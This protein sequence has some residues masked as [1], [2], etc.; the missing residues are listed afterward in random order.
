MSIVNNARADYYNK[1]LHQVYSPPDFFPGR[2]GRMQ[3]KKE[4]PSRLVCSF[5][6]FCLH[7]LYFGG[8]GYNCNVPMTFSVLF[9]CKFEAKSVQVHCAATVFDTKDVSRR[10]IGCEVD[11]D[12]LMYPEWVATCHEISAQMCYC[13]HQLT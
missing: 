4:R 10:F 7:S 12:Q 6:R 8:N 2:G 5:F 1:G 9:R 11:V 3:P 13:A